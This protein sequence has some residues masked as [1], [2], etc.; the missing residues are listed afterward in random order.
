MEIIVLE[1][2]PILYLSI[3]VKPENGLSDVAG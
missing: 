2:N 1:Y 3:S